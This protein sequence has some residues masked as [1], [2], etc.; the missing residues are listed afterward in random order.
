M[1]ISDT[2]TSMQNNLSQAYVALETKNATIP[3]QKNLENLAETISTV[4]AGITF[5]IPYF[6][7]GQYG[8]IAYL[9]ENND[10][11]YYTAPTETSINI[12]QGSAVVATLETGEQIKPNHVVGYSFGTDVYNS[13]SLPMWFLNGYKQLRVLYG[14]ETKNFTSIG[15]YFLSG[16]SSFDC[17]LTLP[18]TVTSIGGYFMTNNIMFNKPLTLSSNLQTISNDFLNNCESFNQ[19]LILP[20]SLTRIYDGFL[21]GC[22]AFNQ[23]LTLPSGL[24]LSGGFMQEIYDFTGPLNVGTVAPPEAKAST[25]ATSSYGGPC[26][27]QGITLTGANAAAWAER[28]PDSAATYYRKLIVAES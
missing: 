19:S 6:D 23:P 25:L 21:W 27:V 12:S 22:K 9:D 16:C 18:G 17:P 28:F 8:T 20:Q 13:V 5:N 15:S 4:K 10:V 26:Y 2:I 11:Q 24:T 7:G 3:E 14:L 1:A